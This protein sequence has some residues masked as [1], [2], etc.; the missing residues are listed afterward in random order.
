MAHLILKSLQPGFFVFQCELIGLVEKNNVDSPEST[1]LISPLSYD[2][3]FIFL[4]CVLMFKCKQLFGHG[5][6]V[7]QNYVILGY[8]ETMVRFF[9]IRK[10]Q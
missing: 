5:Q 3:I 1:V 2:G 10:R 9:L 6:K 7:G 8:I 4:F